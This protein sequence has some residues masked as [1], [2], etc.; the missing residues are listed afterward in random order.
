MLGAALGLILPWKAVVPIAITF[1]CLAG[2]GLATR[3]LAREALPDGR[4][5]ARPAAPPSF[6]ATALFTAYERSAFPNSPAASGFPSC[7]CS[8]SATAIPPRS[9]L[10]R[11]FDGSAARW[12]SSRRRW[13]SNPPLGVMASY[14]LAAV[15]LLAR[16]SQILGPDPPRLVA[17]RARLRPHRHFIWLPAA[18]E[19]RWVDIRQATDDPGYNFENSW[20]F[21][22]PRRPHARTARRRYCAR[23]PAS[24]SSMIAVAVVSPAHRVAPRRASRGKVHRRPPLVDSA[25]RHSFRRALPAASHFPAGLEFAARSSASSNILGAGSRHS[26]R[27]WPSSSPPRSGPPLAARR[28]AVLVACA[29]AF[30][31]ATA[32]AATH[33]FQVCEA[34]DTVASSLAA[35]TMARALKACTSTSPPAPTTRHRHRHA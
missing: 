22:P 26:R 4:R 30:L 6:P 2:T 28:P 24:P 27:Q 33:F 35:S 32:F 18:V 1:L 31:A 10:R 17:S 14:L 7:C 25:R 29:A 11:A 34:D 5:H 21:A 15:A 16:S 12:P 3:A 19:Q 13:L 8:S 9:L 20:L 23:P